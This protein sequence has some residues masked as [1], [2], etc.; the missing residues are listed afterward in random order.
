MALYLFLASSL[1]LSSPP[2]SCSLSKFL[3]F[4]SYSA[5]LHAL[6]PLLAI[7]IIFLAPHVLSHVISFHPYLPLF[8]LSL[9]SCSL[10]TSLSLSPPVIAFIFLSSPH[11][12]ISFALM[13]FYLFL[14]HSPRAIFPTPPTLPLSLSPSSLLIPLRFHLS[15]S[16]SSCC[17]FHLS[18]LTHF[19]ISFALM[20][21]YL[22]LSSCCH[23]P[24][25]P[26]LSLSISLSLYSLLLFFC[27][28]W[29]WQ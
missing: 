29:Q 18:L 8:S 14:S 9:F 17:I 26:T 4:P 25:L 6:P 3:S 2:P 16:L 13:S 22:S 1:C 23:S 24:T 5:S 11:L 15:I 10:F 21:L 7:S 19:F 27:W 28:R 12:S 20:S